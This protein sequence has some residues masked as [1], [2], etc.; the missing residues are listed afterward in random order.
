[1]PSSL[2]SYRSCPSSRKVPASGCNC[3]GSNRNT[4]LASMDLPEPDSPTTQAL[5][6]LH[7]QR[8]VEERVTAVGAFG[9]G[10]SQA[11][12]FKDRHF[13]DS[14]FMVCTHDEAPERRGG[15]KATRKPS[16]MRLTASTHSRIASP[17][18]TLI[19][20]A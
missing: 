19:H 11:I 20:Q 14:R 17:G 1:M 10:D 6:P 12:Y 4:A 15:S 9:Q 13:K 3:S 8:Q 18:S 7:G 2:S 16:P 5:A